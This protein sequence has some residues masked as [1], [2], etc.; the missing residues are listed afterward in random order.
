[1]NL[2]LNRLKQHGDAVIG[3][4][5]QD[6]QKY[7]TLEDI[8]D[9]IS[10]GT[11]RLEPHTH[12]KWELCPRLLPDPEGRSGILI[13]AGNTTEDTRGCILIGSHVEFDDKE[14]KVLNSRI[15]L[16]KF[17]EMLTNDWKTDSLTVVGAYARRIVK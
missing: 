4:I 10:E 7:Y 11:Y 16:K 1:M 12:G 6:G 17:M 9:I 15:A 13:H 8:K 14:A 5:E 2:I 3:E